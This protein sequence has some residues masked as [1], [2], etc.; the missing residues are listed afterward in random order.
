MSNHE[1][2]LIQLGEK[3]RH[4]HARLAQS[5]D[6]DLAGRRLAQATFDPSTRRGAPPVR[7]LLFAAAA[8]GT[9]IAAATAGSR[10]FEHLDSRAATRPS[11]AAAQ[12][13]TLR[14]KVLASAT[15]LDEGEPG[16]VSL[17]RTMDSSGSVLRKGAESPP[18]VAPREPPLASL[19][20][21]AQRERLL[22]VRHASRG[23]ASGSAAAFRLGRLYAD[24]L[25][26]PRE[27]AVWFGTYLA[28]QPQGSL[29]GDARGR[30][31]EC[32]WQSGQKAAAKAE[33]Q[34]YLADYPGGPYAAQAR[35]ILD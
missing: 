21:L 8:L 32:L 29:R 11:A 13:T 1:T 6:L 22:A 20:P 15:D 18:S 10:L 35:R 27:A 30:R 24:L 23:T 16:V 12:L 25:G 34:R 28:E 4:E 7:W 17:P 9:G 33:A 3:V 2:S 31:L 26:N 19:A 14:P 5:S